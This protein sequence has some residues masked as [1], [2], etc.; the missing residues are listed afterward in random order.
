MALNCLV[1]E[2]SAFLYF[3]R[4]T[5]EQTDRPDAWSRSSRSRERRLN[6]WIFETVYPDTVQLM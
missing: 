1:F 4:Q 6:K 2:R 5:D 3:L